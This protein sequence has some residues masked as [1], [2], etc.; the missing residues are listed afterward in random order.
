MTS[1][2]PGLIKS[3]HGGGGTGPA[4]RDD[5][6]CPDTVAASINK[7]LN[8]MNRSDGIYFEEKVNQTGDGRFY[9][10][11]IEVDGTS[12]A[13][14]GR[15]VWFN[16]RLQKVCEIG[17][18]DKGCERFMPADLYHKSREWSAQIAAAANNN[19][20]ATMEALVFHDET[21]ECQ[22]QFIE[23]NRRPQVENEALA[24]LQCDS[25]G[26]R[27]YTFAE[28][29]MRAAGNPAPDFV[30][31]AGGGSEVVLHAR[32][33][34]GNPD[35]D[36]NIAYQP[37]TI[38]GMGGPRLDWVVSEAMSPGAISF[39][40]DPQLG[41][42]VIVAN[43][44]YAKPVVAT[45]AAPPPQLPHQRTDSHHHHQTRRTLV[46]ATSSH[47]PLSPRCIRRKSLGRR[48]ATVGRSTSAP[49]ARSS[50]Y[51]FIVFSASSAFRL[52]LTNL[53]LNSAS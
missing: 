31:M 18:S 47:R 20:R 14:G 53:R 36:S 38:M 35:S 7:V 41:K 37:G 8:E 51:V 27:R 33:L 9:Q 30:P 42:A 2:R 23:C 43:S 44:W 16:S 17:L 25:D 34:H 49:E 40:A 19:T 28:L 21:G 48:C 26:N 50:R 12:V 13:H 39:T 15:F 52:R 32:W 24:L 46:S 3:I 5:P 45:I 29:M 4:H 6:S 10:I 11:E 22:L 1:S